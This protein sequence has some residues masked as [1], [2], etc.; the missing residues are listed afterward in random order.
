MTAYGGDNDEGWGI[1]HVGFGFVMP[2]KPVVSN[3]GPFDDM[4]YCA[5]YEVGNLAGILEYRRPIEWVGMVRTANMEQIDL[6]AMR[7]GYAVDRSRD[8]VLTDVGEDDHWTHL[9]LRSG[10]S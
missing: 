1:H 5:G 10:V 8:H 9:V 2:F 6:I 3:G 7:F 4:A